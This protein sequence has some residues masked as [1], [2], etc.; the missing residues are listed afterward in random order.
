MED[1]LEAVVAVII[2]IA[3]VAKTRSKKS[4]R[5]SAKPEANRSAAKAPAAPQPAKSVQ[6]R[7]AIE[8][9]ID[10]LPAE[11]R[12]VIAEVS[13]REAAAA[14]GMAE[15]AGSDT[16]PA[17]VSVSRMNA[18]AAL[19]KAKKFRTVPK[20]ANEPS[21][22]E[23]TVDEHGCIGGSL[24]EHTAEGESTA[25]H[26]AHMLRAEARRQADEVRSTADTRAAAR[27]EMRRAVV[28]SEILGKPKALRR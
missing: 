22:G 7:A 28:W 20:P 5:K 24:G 11:A 18:E 8:A 17:A 15:S 10:E 21:P 19:N 16:K 13:R 12:Q 26:A 27:A 9:M 1:I 3:A 4:G 2:V 14:P 6:T 23:S 25:V